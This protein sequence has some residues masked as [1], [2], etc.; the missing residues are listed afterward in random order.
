M[1]ALLCECISAYLP[2]PL[3][4]TSGS[5]TKRLSSSS[6]LHSRR[7]CSCIVVRSIS[8][9]RAPLIHKSTYSLLHIPS[10][11]PCLADIGLV[12][13]LPN[14]FHGRQRRSIISIERAHGN[15]SVD[16]GQPWKR[17]FQVR[18]SRVSLTHAQTFSVLILEGVARRR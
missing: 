17:I 11:S 15:M 3:D 13:C 7:P 9:P 6:S 8:I 1:S 5:Y 2:P 12:R 14:G 18:S 4:V 16:E 10:R